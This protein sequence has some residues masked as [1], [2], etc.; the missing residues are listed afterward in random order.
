MSKPTGTRRC[1]TA[2]PPRGA[3]FPVV[4]PEG[5]RLAECAPLEYLLGADTVTV[6]GSAVAQHAGLPMPTKR[7]PMARLGELAGVLV[8]APAYSTAN[9]Y[10]A[11]LPRSSML[12]GWRWHALTVTY[13]DTLRLHSHR[14][15]LAIL[16]PYAVAVERPALLSP[17]DGEPLTPDDLTPLV[18]P[19]ATGTES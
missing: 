14:T 8:Q 1:G 16:R 7:Q 3:F 15:G 6:L 17:D 11:S 12:C 10:G 5:C 4:V 9:T 2:R 13:W 18:F 19:L